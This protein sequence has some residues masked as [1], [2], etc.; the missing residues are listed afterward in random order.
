MA[1]PTFQ[2]GIPLAARDVN[3]LAMEL[4]IQHARASQVNF[5]VEIMSAPNQYNE[6]VAF[7]V[8]RYVFHLHR[9]LH[10]SLTVPY[11][12][13]DRTY[14]LWVG[15]EVGAT[16]TYTAGQ[17]PGYVTGYVDLNSLTTVPVMGQ[18][19][20]VLFARGTANWDNGGGHPIFYCVQESSHTSLT[21]PLPH[22]M[23]TIG[24]TLPATTLNAIS[25]N[26]QAL[27]TIRERSAKQGL[28]VGWFGKTTLNYRILHKNPNLRIKY[29]LYEAGTY[30][31]V[32]YNGVEIHSATVP[33][34]TTAN[35]ID[36]DVTISL[37][38]LNLTLNTWYTLVVNCTGI[39]YY[40]W[41]DG[42]QLR[43]LSEVS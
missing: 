26:T 33:G 27:K 13:S 34:P 18:P 3:A 42:L 31:S 6:S 30:I 16:L 24:T 14:I 10:Y 2:D 20:S 22:A 41:F 12:G 21:S 1:L 40:A 4:E 9:Y 35:S 23:P 7:T 25:E 15:N 32:T 36:A 29:S 39:D 37:A 43:N 38:S 19:Y 11:I 28:R 5:P 8:R 17:T